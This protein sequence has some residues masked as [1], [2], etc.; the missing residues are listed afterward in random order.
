MAGM[1]ILAIE[2]SC[3]QASL[4]LLTDDGLFER[5]LEGHAN[6]SES[7][8]EAIRVLLSE[9]QVSVAELDCIAFGAGPG[10]FT[11][12]RLA[13]GVA[14]GLAIAHQLPLA[15]VCSLAAL[16]AGEHLE[17]ACEVL[18]ATDARMGE[19]YAARYRVSTELIEPAVLSEPVCVAPEGLP[20]PE[21]RGS[22]GVGSAFAVY[23]DRL[24][25][26]VAARLTVVQADRVPQA[27]E[28]AR[29]AAQMYMRGESM[30]AELAGP[31]YVRNKVALTTSERAA[32]AQR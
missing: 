11:G 12:V 18:V 13:C 16:A 3:E 7:L 14:Q 20:V 25:A 6:H 2:T 30:A 29:I 28:V 26:E 10:A 31:L 19:V 8:I 21:T 9:A 32:Q 4:A 27:R 15:P 1:K 22:I 5:A 17:Q 23:G 24:P